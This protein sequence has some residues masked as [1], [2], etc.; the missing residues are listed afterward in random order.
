MKKIFIEIDSFK[1]EHVDTMEILFNVNFQFDEIIEDAGMMGKELVEKIHTAGEIYI[2]S[3]LINLSAT[4]LEN[5]CHYAIER[6]WTDKKLFIFREFA[7]IHW[8]YL[9]H[10]KNLIKVFSEMGNKLYVIADHT[11]KNGNYFWNLVE[12]KLDIEYY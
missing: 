8:S 5:M 4:L 11:D 3:A 12:P 1:R 9:H 10:T 6:N 7:A 2:D